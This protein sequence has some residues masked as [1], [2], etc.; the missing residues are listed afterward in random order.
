MTILVIGATGLLGQEIVIQALEAGYEVKCLVRNIKKATNLRQ[1][2][3]KLVYG[4][5]SLPE[6]IPM[7]LNGIDIVIDASTLR[8][9]ADYHTE[10]IDWYGKLVLLRSAKIAQVQRFIFLS[11]TDIPYHPHVKIMKMKLLFE[12]TL[13]RSNVP[14]TIVRVN[15]FL[16]GLIGEYSRRILN[17][18]AIW[19]MENEASKKYAYVDLNAVAKICLKC[20][21]NISTKNLGII[22]SDKELEFE[23]EIDNLCKT[24]VGPKAE[25]LKI[26]DFL[27][28]LANRFSSIL[29]VTWK[30]T[31]Y[32]Q[33]PRN[34][35][36]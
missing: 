31:M 26:P 19:T 11:T 1:F 20:C 18:N 14:Y 29:E 12:K 5:L 22:I 35:R 8:L 23:K 3:A 9:N 15:G 30:A 10:Q 34:L 25:V 24:I 27:T 36:K 32:G 4:D 6:T 21:Q 28:E 16:Q 33:D 17:E 2:G 13:G 7:G